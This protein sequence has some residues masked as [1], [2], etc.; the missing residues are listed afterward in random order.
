M[1]KNPRPK[2]HDLGLMSSEDPFAETFRAISPASL[3]EADLTHKASLR[4]F[5]EF[6]TGLAT[7]WALRSFLL[8]L[9]RTAGAERI[10]IEI[11]VSQLLTTKQ[12][13]DFLI[14]CRDFGVNYTVRSDRTDAVS[15]WEEL[16]PI[17]PSLAVAGGPSQ[18]VETLRQ[19]GRG[20]SVITTEIA[21]P[22]GII[23]SGDGEISLDGIGFGSLFSEVRLR[24]LLSGGV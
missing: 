10:S 17:I 5:V 11:S 23:I 13:R 7:S 14:F 1:E 9:F 3:G 15:H 24:E 20:K 8:K 16:L 12:F 19:L 22:S 2:F 6:S 21:A 4:I 18:E